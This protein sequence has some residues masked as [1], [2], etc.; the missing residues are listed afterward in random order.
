METI[1]SAAGK[2]LQTY[3][4]AIVYCSQDVGETLSPGP[5][6]PELRSLR[7]R[8]SVFKSTVSGKDGKKQFQNLNP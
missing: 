5:K 2:N 6:D 8:A 1:R 4:Q 7:L 3:A